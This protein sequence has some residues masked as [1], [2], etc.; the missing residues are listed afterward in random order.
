MAIILSLQ[1]GMA[2]GKTTLGRNLQKELKKVEVS[3]EYP[4]KRPEGLD[5]FKEDDY[6]EIQRYFINL[7]VERYNNL[8]NK[9]VIIDLGPEEIEFYT[10]LFP[11][12]IGQDWNVEDTLRRELQDLRKCKLDGILFLDGSKEVLYSRKEADPGRKRGSF[13]N[14]IRYLHL[15]KKAWFE[16]KE[17]TTFIN[18][19]NLTPKELETWTLQWLK[20]KWNLE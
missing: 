16:K 20:E 11:K 3:Y 10:L 9:N 6:Y 17:N 1:G 2:V 15:F 8:A 14:Y 7:E 18:V 13:D 19:D 12:S 5:M 4:K